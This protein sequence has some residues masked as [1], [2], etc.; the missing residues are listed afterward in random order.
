MREVTLVDARMLSPN[1]RELTFAAGRELSFEPGQWINLFFPKIRN[2]LG[3]PLKRAYSIA[4][5]PNAEDRIDL[6]VTQVRD[7]PAST[8]LHSAELGQSF[9][10]SGPHG[11]FVL[12]PIVR[13][14]LMVATGTGV[15]PF[16]SMLQSFANR[17]SQSIS[18]LLGVRD[19]PDILYREEFESLERDIPTFTFH[20]TLSRAPSHWSGKRGH[21]QL[22]LQQSLL[23]LGEQDCDVY[24]CGLFRMV[25]DVRRILREELG[26]E[27]KFIHVERYD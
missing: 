25:Y 23:E 15:A 18:L 10:M 24:V 14:V 20:P 22:H 1:V 13:P 5:A 9:G 8:G 21:V 16:R 12:A 27:P 26:I 2:E 19:Q 17:V 11:T 3:K 4:S 6:A 7:G